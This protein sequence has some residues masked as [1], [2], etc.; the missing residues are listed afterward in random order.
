MTY[1]PYF[2]TLPFSFLNQN[3]FLNVI[4]TPKHMIFP[5]STYKLIKKSTRNQYRYYK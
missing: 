1:P 5:I 2:E 3:D 4:I